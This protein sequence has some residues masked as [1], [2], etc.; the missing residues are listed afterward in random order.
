ML[1]GL[2]NLRFV[3][4]TRSVCVFKKMSRLTGSESRFHILP[5]N[6]LQKTWSFQN[7]E[8]HLRTLL[9][10]TLQYST[11]SIYNFYEFIFISATPIHS[12]QI[13]HILVK[14]LYI[15]KYCTAI[16]YRILYGYTVQNTV[17]L[18]STEYCTAIQYRM[19]FS[20][21]FTT[22]V[23]LLKGEPA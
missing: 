19:Y 5:V 7:E 17:R 16:Q 15:F 22:I 4:K 1:L 20:D 2:G 23:H 14:S 10:L 18:Y 13:C 6:I 11:V 12:I 9:D 3:R 8:Y 21:H